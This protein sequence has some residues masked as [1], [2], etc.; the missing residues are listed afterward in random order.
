MPMGGSATGGCN[1]FTIP[2]TIDVDTI[3]DEVTVSVVVFV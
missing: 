1:S 2:I 3:K